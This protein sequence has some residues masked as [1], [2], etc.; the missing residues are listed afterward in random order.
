MS[1]DELFADFLREKKYL[2][3]VSEWTTDFY[4]RSYKAYKRV[5][6]TDPTKESL[7]EFVIG[8]KISGI[9]IQSI[10]CYIRGMNSFLSWLHEN[11]HTPEKLRIKQLPTEK[12]GKPTYSETHLKAILSWK[13]SLPARCT[14]FYL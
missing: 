5:V 12:K 7:K 2:Q 8:L 13:P 1:L 9:S 3:N 14:V 11:G 4:K 6:N 10:N